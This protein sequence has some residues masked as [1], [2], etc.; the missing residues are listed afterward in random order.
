MISFGR[1]SVGVVLA[2]A[3]AS[4]GGFVA[5]N[6]DGVGADDAGWGDAGA[7]D[8]GTD[9]DHPTS[10]DAGA[11]HDGGRRSGTAAS[12]TLA[13]AADPTGA[14][15]L[16]AGNIFVLNEGPADGGPIV[17]ERITTA[18][19]SW[20]AGHLGAGDFLRVLAEGADEWDFQII[21]TPSVSAGTYH[22]GPANM[23][24]GAQII[25]PGTICNEGWSGDVTISELVG[26]ADD[27]VVDR[28]R[29]SFVL[30]CEADG[31]TLS[32]CVG[33]GN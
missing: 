24:Q 2:A 13:A 26:G 14:P 29:A 6:G 25:A 5:S 21:H 11:S 17:Q 18:S 16:V 27:Y 23:E 33:Y 8:A 30:H 7:F 31:Q 10:A 4:C 22:F 15:C 28:V 3:L 1:A 20:S 32:G 12:G 9:A 19:A